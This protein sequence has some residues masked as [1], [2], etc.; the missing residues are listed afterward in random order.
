M[1]TS[2]ISS[3][4]LLWIMLWWKHS[5]TSL[6]INV[7]I[8]EISGGRD[9]RP[10]ICEHV[11]CFRYILPIC[12]PER[13]YHFLFPSAEY[14]STYLSAHCLALNNIFAHLMGNIRKF[15]SASVS[16]IV[17]KVSDFSLF[18]SM[19][20]LYPENFLFPLFRFLLWY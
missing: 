7:S 10:N 20:M 18:V 8:G 15:F 17:S 3:L 19:F 9:V 13:S 6:I 11:Q 1:K 4:Y 12:P 14:E 2:A 16:F 5:Y